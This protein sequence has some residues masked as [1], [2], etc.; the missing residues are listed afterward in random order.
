MLC[1]VISEALFPN[2]SKD[3]LPYTKL[4]DYLGRV[5]TFPCLKVYINCKWYEGFVDAIIASIKFCTV[6]LSNIPGAKHPGVEESAMVNE[7]PAPQRKTHTAKAVTYK[8][9][10]KKSSA[11]SPASRS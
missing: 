8:R 5:N 7:N 3:D 4:S 6:L 1:V 9:N 11:P 2:L 10:G